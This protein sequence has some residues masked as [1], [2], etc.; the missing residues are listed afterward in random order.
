M[1]SFDVTVDYSMVLWWH[2][3]I[4]RHTSVSRIVCNILRQWPIAS[5][6]VAFD[7]VCCPYFYWTKYV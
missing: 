1:I 6:S 2:S 5:W 7:C 3:G 4:T